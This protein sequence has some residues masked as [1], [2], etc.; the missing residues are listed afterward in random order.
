MKF[1][2]TLRTQP[3][4][5]LFTEALV[6][7]GVLGFIDYVTTWELSLFV[8]YA[9]PILLV[10]WYADRRLALIFA[11]GCALAWWL[12]N[13][14]SHPYKTSSAYLWATINRLAYFV[15]VAIGGTAMKNERETIRARLEAMERTRELEREIVRVSEHEQRRI[16]QD[17][18][19]G[20]CQRLAAI[21]CAAACLKD[22]LAEKSLPEADAANLIQKQ[23]KE[24]VVEARDL[25]RGIFPVQMDEEGFP[26]A[27]E[28][29]VTTTNRL[30][31]SSVELE[32]RGEMKIADPQVGMHLYRIAQEALSNAAKHACA[33]HVTITLSRDERLLTMTIADDGNGL[34][35]ANAPSRGIGL[36]TM[37]YR[38][39]SMGGKLEVEA[40]PSGGTLI[41]CSIPA[42]ITPP[43][44]LPND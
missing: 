15:F 21:G 17:L 9:V 42:T 29:L 11:F 16:G 26:S 1:S 41:R 18:H 39:R 20:L 28:E 30:R 44:A 10:A 36:Q 7:I 24:A 6:L 31:Q 35:N 22:D 2:D 3:K 23:L 37:S 43:S 5:L 14:S 4:A 12:A 19:D 25:A 38:A 32:V 13:L 34:A 8:F 27:L 40:N 33:S